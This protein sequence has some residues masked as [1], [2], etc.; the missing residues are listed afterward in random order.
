M[1]TLRDVMTLAAV[2]LCAGCSAD[3]RLTP[4]EQLPRAV[5]LANAPIDAKV[6]ARVELP[7]PAAE[8]GQFRIRVSVT[9]TRADTVVG[10]VCADHVDGRP[11]G[12]LTW[13]DASSP[14]A[15]C[16]RQAMVLAPGASGVITAIADRAR[17]RDLTM[18]SGGVVWI[19]AR[20]TL[21]SA[22]SGPIGMQSDE[23]GV[24]VQ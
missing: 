24:S 11:F 19:R 9:N 16:T 23:A 8:N 3:D 12:L 18:G 10:A 13:Y 2:V 5:P 15:G 7:L 14:E 20:M 17:L 4:L 1:Q 22:T 21:T 6:V